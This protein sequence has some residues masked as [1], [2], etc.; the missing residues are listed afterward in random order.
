MWNPFRRQPDERARITGN[1]SSR[2]PAVRAAYL[3]VYPQCAVCG[4]TK[5]LEV[6][7]IIPVNV[8][9][10]LELDADNNLIVLCGDKGRNCHFVIGHACNWQLYRPEIVELSRVIRSYRV[11]G[12]V[13]K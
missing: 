10:Y 11:C 2:W 9:P 4:G 6:H 12:R 5:D 1:R 8:A 13:D 3:R 7:H